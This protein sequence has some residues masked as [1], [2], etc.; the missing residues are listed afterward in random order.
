VLTENEAKGT[1]YSGA[2]NLS[3]ISELRSQPGHRHGVPY[4]SRLVTRP[5]ISFDQVEGVPD[6]AAEELTLLLGEKP[7]KLACVG[8]AKCAAIPLSI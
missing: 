1:A 6:S 7:P 2:V 4:G 5:G 8:P 3:H